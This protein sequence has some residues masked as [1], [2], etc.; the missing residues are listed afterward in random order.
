MKVYPVEGRLIRDPRSMRVVPPE[1]LDVP[2][3]DPF[4][5]QRVSQ[6]DLTTAS[7]AEHAP[8]AVRAPALAEPAT[9]AA[10]PSAAG[11]LVIGDNAPQPEH[12]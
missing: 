10:P 4:F 9:P 7:P 2:D 5:I 3:F 1:G 12:A 6:G 11:T 8:P